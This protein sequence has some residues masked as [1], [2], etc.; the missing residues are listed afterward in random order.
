[1]K[2]NTLVIGLLIAVAVLCAYIAFYIPRSP[3]KG[4][5]G[6]SSETLASLVKDGQRDTGRSQTRVKATY[7]DRKIYSSTQAAA[8]Y[9]NQKHKNSTFGPIICERWAVVTTVHAPTQAVQRQ[10]HLRGL[11]AD[12]RRGRWCVVVVADAGGLERYTLESPLRNFVYLSEQDQRLWASG[13]IGGSTAQT[14]FLKALPWGHVGRKNAGYLYAILHGAK[15]IWDFDDDVMIMSKHATIPTPGEAPA[16]AGALRTS[17]DYEARVPS[18]PYASEA[19]NP[20]P[21]FE[22]NHNPSWP[23][24]FPPDRILRD[25]SSQDAPLETTVARVP[26]S[27]VAV[28]Q[29]LAN[30]DPDVDCLYRM[31][32]PLPLDFPI[33]GQLPL[34]LPSRE[35][36]GKSPRTLSADTASTTSTEPAAVESTTGPAQAAFPAPAAVTAQRVSPEIPSAEGLVFAPYNAQSTLHTS[37]ALWALLLPLGPHPRVSDIWRS[38]IAQRLFADVGVRVA[39]HSPI[40]THMRKAKE[41][42]LPDLHHELPLFTDTLDLLR[43]LRA[44]K[45]TAA[46]LPGRVEELYIALYEQ[47]FL[48]LRD[49]QL[50][51]LWLGALLDAGYVFPELRRL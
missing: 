45:S 50:A 34:I 6:E 44:W 42:N 1:M 14:D 8:K 37:S 11:D 51:Q 32:R 20:F 38:Y 33:H 47:G 48:S 5:S 10:A 21:L 36:V 23:R 25:S 17:P 12:G 22:A 15:Y 16:G 40:V 41:D 13:T 18:A 29:F 9:L 31:I 19:F 35:G 7:K 28:V 43:T 39:F 46:T 30:H 2:S 4:D 27:S 3:S 24:G 49:V 26:A